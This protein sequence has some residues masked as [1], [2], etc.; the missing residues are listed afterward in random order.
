MLEA[1]LSSLSKEDRAQ[2]MRLGN[3]NLH[4]DAAVSIFQTNAV[5]VG[6]DVAGVCPTF[7][8]INHACLGGFN[9]VYHWREEQQDISESDVEFPETCVLTIAQSFMRHGI[10]RRA[11]NF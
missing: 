9:V 7:S 1:Q 10:S 11:R 6:K 4:T 3:A 2:F 8:R 5:T